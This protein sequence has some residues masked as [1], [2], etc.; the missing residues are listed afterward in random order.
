MNFLLE[1]VKK[2]STFNLSY[3]SKVLISYA[4]AQIT[5]NFLRLIS[6]FIVVS[7]LEPEDYG[8]FTGAGVYLGYI[9][10][11]HGG[12]INGLSRELPFELGRQNENY[13]KELANSTFSVCLIISGI[14]FFA[15]LAAGIYHISRGSLI[16]GLTCF[17]YTI[18]SGLYLL[19]KQFLPVLY[20]TNKDFDS[21]SSQNIKLGIS[22]FSSTMLVYFAGLYGLMLRSVGLA[23]YEFY[24]LYKNKPYRI[25]W[26]INPGHLK[27]LIKTGLPI[28]SVGYINPFWSTT[29]DNLIISMGGPLNYGLY[30]LSSIVQ[31]AVG[32]LP[33]AFSQVVYPRMAIMFGEGEPV[34]NILKS[35]IKPLVFQFVL[36]LII[37]VI[38]A[39]L[40]PLIIPIILPKH[41]EGV[42]AAQY[43]MFVPAVQSLGLL[44]NIFNVTKQQIWYF[45]SLASGALIGTLYIVIKMNQTG[46]ALESIPQGL[47]I[48][49]GFQQLFT[50][51]LLLKVYGESAR[52]NS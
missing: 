24:L 28:F 11:G 8:K 2:I 50:G 36:L 33:N 7:L 43:M 1:K 44:N 3:F 17:S 30:A 26:N 18:V 45:V 42:L 32:I 38:G 25:Y 10:L 20:R 29:L 19:N 9:L 37:G 14:A 21:L 40:L 35:N 48:G 49:K 41:K 15:Y 12:I 31:G 23:I 5:S 6:G 16:L 34:R 52:E 51:L 22:N 47:L 13:A 27:K 4:S 46:F 39:L